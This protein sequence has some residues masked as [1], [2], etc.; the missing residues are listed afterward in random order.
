VRQP[1]RY[2]AE[3]ALRHA[4]VVPPEN[5]DKPR[6]EPMAGPSVSRRAVMLGLSGVLASACGTDSA[7]GGNDSGRLVRVGL[8]RISPHLMAP[9]FYARFLPEGLRVETL[10]FNNSTEIKTA[11]VTGSVDFAVTGVTAALQGASRGEPFRVLAAAADG[12]SAI[13][14]RK[15]Q[16]ILRIED[17][18]GKRV[19]YVPGSAQDVLLRLSLRERG[20]SADKD[21]SLVKVGFGDMPN[22]LERGDIDAFSGAETGPSVALLRGRSNVVLYPYE[23]KMGKINIVFGT[24]QAML[25]RDPD[26]CRAMVKTHARATEHLQKNPSEW[27][28]ATTKAWGARL[29]AVE[30]AIRNI[31]LRWRLD[32]AY[33][34]QAR[35]LGEELERLR[36]VKQQP[37]YDSFIS[38]GFARELAEAAG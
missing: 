9:R 12:A 26:L 20:L 29:E 14:A 8:L 21:V 38:S 6:S 31:D 28:K 33:V 25:E 36:Q 5:L 37:A 22:A 35:V 34:D 32:D 19:G 17:L 2:N 11:V 27:A 4:A 10:A 18:K 3:K 15:E 7:G 23:T 30:L 13:V 16:G 1:A 24:S